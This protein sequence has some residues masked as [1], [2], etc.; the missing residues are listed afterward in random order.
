[1]NLNHYREVLEHIVRPE[2]PAERQNARRVTLQDYEAIYM[3]EACIEYA[4][5]GA[6]TAT[7]EKIALGYHQHIHRVVG[8][9]RLGRVN[10]YAH[11]DD[12]VNVLGYV[13]DEY[14]DDVDE[15]Q[16]TIM[17]KYEDSVLSHHQQ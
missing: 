3:A 2:E 11:T 10:L 1:M 6:D 17:Q 15:L 7:E 5:Y 4:A 8:D 9:E 16:E 12:A 14:A 13:I